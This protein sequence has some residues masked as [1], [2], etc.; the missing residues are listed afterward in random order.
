MS[1]LTV[2]PNSWD[3]GFVWICLFRK[4]SV[5]DLENLE[6]GLS[7]VWPREGWAGNHFTF[8]HSSEQSACA[9]LG[10]A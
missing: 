7:W 8:I 2:D 10:H 1:L 6:M 3:G 9:A 5:G 4:W